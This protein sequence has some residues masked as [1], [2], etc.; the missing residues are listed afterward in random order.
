ML[1]L[2]AHWET[3]YTYTHIK[4][5]LSTEYTFEEKATIMFVDWQ[6]VLKASQPLN[7]RHTSYSNFI[8]QLCG[9]LLSDFLGYLISVD[10][11]E[12]VYDSKDPFL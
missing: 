7:D 12:L 3:K 1:F 4:M 6:Y 5:I 8:F 9:I 2:V 11:A 10:V